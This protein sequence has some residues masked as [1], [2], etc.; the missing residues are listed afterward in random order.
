MSDTDEP[1]RYPGEF[2]D[3]AGYPDGRGFLSQDQQDLIREVLDPHAPAFAFTAVREEE[4]DR[5]AAVVGE[6]ELGALTYRAAGSGAAT[7]SRLVLE[8]TWIDP[9]LRGQGLATELVRQVLDDVR[10]R[11]ETILIECPIVATF[12]EHHADYADLIDTETSQN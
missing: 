1:T 4:H 5:Y 10:R 11:G 6:R 8:S 7:G 12:I 2:P 9:E 3:E